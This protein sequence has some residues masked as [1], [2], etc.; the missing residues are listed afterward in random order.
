MVLLVGGSREKLSPT[1]ATVEPSEMQ[2]PSGAVL[3]G[4]SQ[5]RV[6]RIQFGVGL[7]CRCL[8]KYHTSY[9]TEQPCR[10]G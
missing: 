6:S 8:A 2:L 5:S 1:T 4:F 9:R 3:S 10:Y 7:A